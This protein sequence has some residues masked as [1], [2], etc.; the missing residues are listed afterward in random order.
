MSAIKLFTTSMLGLV[1]VFPMAA[2]AFQTGDTVHMTGGS[3]V[4]QVYV[5]A[6]GASIYRFFVIRPTVDH[7]RVRSAYV[8]AC[9]GPDEA[10]CAASGY[11]LV[12]VNPDQFSGVGSYG[13]LDTEVDL[14]MVWKKRYYTTL[15]GNAVADIGY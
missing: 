8:K 10:T 15:Y 7:K 6:E 4:K 11:T 12:S 5:T 2:S 3:Y 9:V 13:L 1:L 14:T